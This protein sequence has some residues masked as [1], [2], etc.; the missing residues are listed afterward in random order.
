MNIDLQNYFQMKLVRVSDGRVMA[1]YTMYD[2]IQSLAVSANNWFVLIGTSDRRLF[3][4]LIV[5]PDEP[6]HRSRIRYVRK[7]N[8]PLSHDE[9]LELL[10]RASGLSHDKD[11]SGT[12]CPY[13]TT[14]ITLYNCSHYAGLFYVHMDDIINTQT[15]LVHRC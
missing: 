13:T 9:A 12:V 14:H 2:P 1:W 6:K 5:D 15:V 7:F 10:K 11:D 8:P 4:L 3:V